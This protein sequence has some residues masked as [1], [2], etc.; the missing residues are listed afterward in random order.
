[1]QSTCS[2]KCMHGSIFNIIYNIIIV[3]IILATFYNCLHVVHVYNILYIHVY[4][5]IG[6]CMYIYIAEVAH[7][8]YN[9]CNKLYKLYMHV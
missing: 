9:Y 4:I 1:M 7:L 5:I 8:I 2:I 6:M 3:I